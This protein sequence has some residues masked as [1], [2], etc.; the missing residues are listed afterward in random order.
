MTG[1][2]PGA[3]LTVAGRTVTWPMLQRLWGV[4]IAAVLVVA[5]VPYPVLGVVADDEVIHRIHNTVGAV[6]YLLLWA[7]AVV[8]WTW[9]RRD[10]AAWNVAVASA[11]AMCVTSAPSGDLVASMSILPLVTLAPLR[12]DRA[13]I[14][15]RRPRL[16]LLLLG[17]TAVLSVL[18]LRLAPDL[19]RVQDVAGGDLHGVRFHY[20]GMAAVYV[21]LALCTLV[22][23]V[24]TWSPAM[25]RWIGVSSVLVGVLCLIW[26]RYD[27]ALPTAESWWYVGCGA[28]VLAVSLRRRAGSGIDDRTVAGADAGTG[29]PVDDVADR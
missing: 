28:A 23:A 13:C 14:V 20:G 22:V 18:A 21:A 27:S 8:V 26:P 10:R 15:F 1:Q 19:V 29:V 4:G 6:H 25:A 16:D 5:V 12:P 3:G 7:P 24:G 17:P 2:S 9:R 11:V